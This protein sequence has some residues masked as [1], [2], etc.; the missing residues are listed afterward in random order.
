MLLDSKI[1]LIT[2]MEGGRELVSHGIGDASLKTYIL[3]QD[4]PSH[5]QP[6]RDFEGLYIEGPAARE[7]KVRVLVLNGSKWQEQKVVA[8]AMELGR[9]CWD[10][11]GQYAVLV[12]DQ[13]GV[14]YCGRDD[15][16]A[17]YR[18]KGKT[19]LPLVEL[20]RRLFHDLASFGLP[21]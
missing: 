12:D 8:T 2:Y 19:A 1:Y 6:K 20:E 4:P 14:Y 17:A 5:F 9:L 16:L 10:L 21:T 7:V 3:S 11:E 15:L 18:G 13:Q